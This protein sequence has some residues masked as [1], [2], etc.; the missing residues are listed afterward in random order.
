M[1][2]WPAGTE[3]FGGLAASDR[4][5]FRL[6]SLPLIFDMIIAYLTAEIDKVKHIFDDPDKFVSADPFLFMLASIIVLGLWTW[7]VFPRLADWKK[8]FP[9]TTKLPKADELLKTLPFALRSALALCLILSA[10][11]PDQAGARTTTF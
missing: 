11:A 3:C 1:S 5:G 7:G 8:T 6:I 4:P 9:E 10:C 2:I